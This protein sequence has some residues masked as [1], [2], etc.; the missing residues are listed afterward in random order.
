MAY[1]IVR[2]CHTTKAGP[3]DSAAV[4]LIRFPFQVRCIGIAFAV[5]LNA[6]NSLIVKRLC[7]SRWLPLLVVV[8]G[9]VLAL[10]GFVTKYDL[11]VFA[12][13][14]R[15]KPAFSYFQLVV[16]RSL[17]GLAEAG[18]APGVIY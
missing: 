6:F 7:P 11:S 18:L 16:S 13:H 10:T 15:M 5:T 14:H 2:K 12:H 4:L 8:W 17:L 3:N 9:T 1:F